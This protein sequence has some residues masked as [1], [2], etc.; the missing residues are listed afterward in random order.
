M[1]KVRYDV[2][3]VEPDGGDVIPAGVYQAAISDCQYGE[4][5]NGND[6]FTV[7]LTIK[8]GPFDGRKLWH[9][10]LPKQA[11]FRMREFIDALALPEGGTIDTDAIVGTVVQVR[12]KVEKSEE[13]G[14]QARI[15]KLIPAVEASGDDVEAPYSEWEQSELKD[16]VEARELTIPGRKTKAAMIAALEADDAAAEGGESEDDEEEEDDED[17]E[18]SGVTA[19]EIRV[20][21]RAALKAMIKE[22]DALDI[23][24]LKSMSDE[25]LA[26]AII[27]ALGL[28]EEAETEVDE[29]EEDDEDD[30][31]EEEDE[32]DEVD[33]N[34][35]EI[36]DLKAEL[37]ERGLKPDGKKSIL[38]KRLETDDASKDDD[39]PF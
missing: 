15:Q 10:V 16:E 2:S 28:T 27:D 34:E 20:L 11:E 33:Y 23:R 12:T 17:E 32:D 14:E 18:E 13:Y 22:D 26:E 37:K 36:A 39:A 21:D 6:M 19:E 5:K 4:S 9:Y 29:E 7:E 31:D 24:V 35:W 3:G 38:V 1:P 30:E 8:G 25:D